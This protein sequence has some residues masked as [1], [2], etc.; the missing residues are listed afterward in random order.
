MYKA[1]RITPDPGG[2]RIVVDP[3]RCEELG[4]THVRLGVRLPCAISV[5]QA[6]G[7]RGA[8]SPAGRRCRRPKRPP[9]A[10]GLPHSKSSRNIATTECLI[11]IPSLKTKWH[12]A[13]VRA[14]RC[15]AE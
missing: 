11:Q 10:K 2:C 7:L 6:L 14:P 9:Q 5:G 4:A 12:C 3:D 15:L 1:G 8:L 13:G